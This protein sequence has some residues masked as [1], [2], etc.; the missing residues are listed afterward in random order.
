MTST[1]TAK[2]SIT[3][4]ATTTLFVSFI[5]KPAATLGSSLNPGRADAVCTNSTIV[6]IS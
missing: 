1:A 3:I 6:A 5:L 4:R 2:A